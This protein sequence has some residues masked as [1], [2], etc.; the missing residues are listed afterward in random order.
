[1]FWR[2]AYLAKSA[3]LEH[4]P[5]AFWLTEA[6]RPRVFV[7]LGTHYGASYFAFC[8]A[9]ERLALDTRCYAIDTWKGDEHAGCYPV[10]FTR[11]VDICRSG[12]SARR[13]VAPFASR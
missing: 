13:L 5:F 6:H 7:E 9:V 4:L 11:G 1:M 3:W 10:L 2:P 12:L 8:Q